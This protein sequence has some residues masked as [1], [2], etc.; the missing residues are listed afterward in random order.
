MINIEDVIRLPEGGTCERVELVTSRGTI[1][2]RVHPAEGERAVL[3]VFGA[4]G[5]LGGPAGG[6]YTRL[7][8]QL[9]PSRVT[10]LELDYR[11]PGYLQ[12]CVIDVLVGLAYLERLGKSRTVLVGHSFGGAVVINA[13]LLSE[14]VVAVAALSSQ[15]AGTDQVAKLS[16]KPLLLMHGEADEVLPA[17]CSYDIHARAGDPKEL[18]LYP[19]CW[20]GLDQCR[21]PLD[22]DLTRWLN[23]VL[24]LGEEPEQAKDFW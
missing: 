13:G 19:G 22:R 15:T 21:D 2:C 23:E 10:S 4:G 17:S 7:G 16:P 9:Q 14:A 18:I 24:G 5:G 11:R 12:E 1:T 8:G 6:V 20:H 3:W